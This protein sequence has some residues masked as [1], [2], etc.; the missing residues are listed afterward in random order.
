MLRKLIK[1]SKEG[2]EKHKKEKKKKNVDVVDGKSSTPSA[3]GGVADTHLRDSAPAPAS[4][5]PLTFEQ[6]VEVLTAKH[7]SW[8]DSPVS[9][10]QNIINLF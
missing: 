4:R 6:T 8:L 7:A 3:A 1:R 5:A 9:Q 2:K 10:I